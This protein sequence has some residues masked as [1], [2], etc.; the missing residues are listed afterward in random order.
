MLTT[1]VFPSFQAMLAALGRRTGA[2]VHTLSQLTLCKLEDHLTPALDPRRLAKPAEGNHSRRRTF[3]LRLTFWS[4]VWQILQ[5]NTAC[6][7]VVRQSPG[8]LWPA[9]Q[10]ASGQRHGGLLHGSKQTAQAHVGA[11]VCR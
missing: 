2:A 11:G 5:G 8:P 10:A 1:P 7:E 3:D 4:W 9:R 6:R